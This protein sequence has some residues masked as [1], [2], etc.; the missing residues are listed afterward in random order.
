[1]SSDDRTAQPVKLVA[2]ETDVGVRLDAFLA[3]H[4]TE[5]SRSKLRR[6]IDAG[7]VLVDGVQVKPS[8]HLRF[9]QQIEVVLPEPEATGPEPE[10]IPLTIIFEDETLAV[11]DKPPGM[12]VHPS[13][14][15]GSGTLAAAIR[16]HFE[17]LS[18]IGGAARPGIVHRLD[19]DTSGV[20]VVAKTDVAHAKLAAQFADRTTEKEYHAIVCGSPDRDRD[21]VEH[22]IGPHPREREKMAVRNDHPDSR[23]A[24]TFFE[25]TERFDRYALLSVRPKTGRT[26]QIRV[27]LSSVGLPVLCDRLYGGRASITRGELADAATSDKQATSNIEVALRRQALHAHRLQIAHPTTGERLEFVAAMPDDMSAA[28]EIL[29][30]R[31]QR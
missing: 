18:G 8:T 4:L 31:I 17:H 27:H 28:I 1:M 13:K 16:Y 19:R 15:H 2:S 20:I 22:A 7:G 3:R 29:R 21:I 24:E 14:G 25:V 30:K 23:P 5:Y 6:T 11:I 26:H 12:V 10:A 9:G